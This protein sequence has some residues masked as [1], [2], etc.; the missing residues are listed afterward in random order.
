MNSF[1]ALRDLI[2][3]V[4]DIGVAGEFP[5]LEETDLIFC[6]EQINTE[7]KRKEKATEIRTTKGKKKHREARRREAHQLVKHIK[8]EAPTNLFLER[9]PSINISS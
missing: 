1:P 4:L 5:I 2:G 7:G 9:K 8:F 6:R 3:Q